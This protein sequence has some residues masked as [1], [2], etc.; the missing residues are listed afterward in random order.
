LAPLYHA[1]GFVAAF[2]DFAGALN[3]HRPGAAVRVELAPAGID[4]PLVDAGRIGRD[5]G[6]RPRYDLDKAVAAYLGHL[7]G[8]RP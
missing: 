7:Q 5:T 8:A 1:S 2:A 3:R 4:Y 6:F